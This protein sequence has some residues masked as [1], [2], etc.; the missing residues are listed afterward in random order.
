MPPTISKGRQALTRLLP[1]LVSFLQL[2]HFFFFRNRY[3]TNI[4]KKKLKQKEHHAEPTPAKAHAQQTKIY[5]GIL[6]LLWLFSF[7]LSI[8][9]EILFLLG[10]FLLTGS[11]NVIMNSLFSF[12]I[13]DLIFAISYAIIT[14]I[15]IIWLAIIVGINRRKE[16][17]IPRVIEHAPKFL[18][19]KAIVLAVGTVVSLA[20]I[21]PYCF[22]AFQS[23]NLLNEQCVSDDTNQRIY[24]YRWAIFGIRCIVIVPI[25]PLIIYVWI[26][27]RPATEGI[28]LV[29]VLMYR[30]MM[31]VLFIAQ[32]FLYFLQTITA[33]VVVFFPD[34]SYSNYK[35]LIFACITIPNIAVIA[36][37]L[38]MMKRITAKSAEDSSGYQELDS[39]K[40]DS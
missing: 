35:N 16:V 34:M 11:D 28:S 10:E 7:S 2:S 8:T 40:S 19:F 13:N 20:A 12:W 30:K 33:W 18:V 23:N 36:G 4:K 21:R 14:V 38:F 6:L 25:I 31:E 29:K 26:S 9:G 27:L 17:Q 15:V 22:P 24:L 1:S 3:T 5:L 39:V 32:I 37:T